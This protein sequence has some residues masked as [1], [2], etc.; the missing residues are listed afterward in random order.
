M[1]LITGFSL[2]MVF[3]M[4]KMMENMDPEALKELQQQQANQP[5]LEMPDVSSYMANMFAPPQTQQSDTPKTS[6][7]KN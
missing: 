7:K 4:P 2:I 1:I 5:K 6:K 3:V